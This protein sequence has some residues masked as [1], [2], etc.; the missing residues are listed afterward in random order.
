MKIEWLNDGTNEAIVTRGFWLW[1]R[2]AHV[3]L[4]TRPNEYGTLRTAWRYAGND[5]ECD[6]DFARWLDA[7]RGEEQ[8]RRG[9]EIIRRA[10]EPNWQPVRPMPTARLVERKS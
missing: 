5:A 10:S 7:K 3:V 6:Y 9:H 8:L 4:V 1:K 2:Q